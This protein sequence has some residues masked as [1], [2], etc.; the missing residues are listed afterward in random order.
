MMFFF[1]NL[2]LYVFVQDMNVPTTYNSYKQSLGYTT[3][4]VHHV[5]KQ[6]LYIIAE[7]FIVICS[8]SSNL[9]LSFSFVSNIYNNTFKRY[10]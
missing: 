9:N 6:Y 10:F 3:M 5:Y 7:N 1:F 2:V 4:Q 8:E